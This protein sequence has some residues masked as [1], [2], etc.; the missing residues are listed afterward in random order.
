MRTGS[1]ALDRRLGLLPEAMPHGKPD[2][3][4][5]DAS[6]GAQATTEDVRWAL[7]SGLSERDRALSLDAIQ[8]PQLGPARDT[9]LRWLSEARRQARAR[10]PMWS[11]V[12]GGPNGDGK[13][14]LLKALFADCLRARLSCRMVNDV[15]WKDELISATKPWSDIGVTNVARR[16]ARP[17]VI[18]LDDLGKAEP[19][20][21][22]CEQLYSLINRR[23]EQ[24]RPVIATTD[25]SA[26]WLERCWGERGPAIVDRLEGMCLGR[27][28]IEVG[29]ESLRQVPGGARCLAEA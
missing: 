8:V 18:G 28:W 23:Y 4:A 2:P 6:S 11:V 15:A 17:W 12:L 14:L 3:S 9:L 26:E 25:R 1:V 27:Y 19:S 16:Y 21:L 24:G 5:C 20:P 13:T 22:Y 10:L 29:G 7:E